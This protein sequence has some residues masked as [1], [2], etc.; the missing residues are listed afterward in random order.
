M[1]TRTH[2]VVPPAPTETRQVTE[3]LRRLLQATPLPPAS[4]DLDVVLEAFQVAHAGRQSVLDEL[5]APLGISSDHDRE[6]VREICARQ[7]AWRDALAAAQRALVD[8]RIGAGQLRHYAA[9]NAGT[10]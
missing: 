2:A 4:D 10:L 6:L 5:R 8:Q 9:A 3:L 7:D 1:T